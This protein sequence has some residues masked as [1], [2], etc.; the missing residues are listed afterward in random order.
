MQKI[1]MRLKQSSSLYDPHIQNDSLKDQRP[2][3]QHSQTY[4]DASD[5][6]V[7]LVKKLSQDTNKVRVSVG[8]PNSILGVNS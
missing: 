5:K 7:E 3:K 8:K 2:K 1:Q 6:Q 4:S